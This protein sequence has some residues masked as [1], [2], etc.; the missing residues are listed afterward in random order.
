LE[1]TKR[2]KKVVL[3][4]DG[5]V[6]SSYAFSLLQ[7]GVANELSVVDIKAKERHTYGDI[8]DL[9]DVLPLT[10]PLR[11]H[12]GS[13]QD[14]SDAD[15]VVITAGVPRKSGE[16]RLDLV[17]KNTKI[18][19]SIIQPIIESGF[20]GIFLISCNPVDI[21]TTLTQKL[22]G[23]PKERVIGTGTMLDTARLQVALS[24]RLNVSLQDIDAM[25]LGEHGDSSFAAYGEAKIGGQL[26][27][28]ISS[29][30]SITENDLLEIQQQVH[31]KGNNIIENKGSTFYGVAVVLMR[32]TKAILNNES[33]ITPISAPLTGQ[34]GLKD[35][36]IGTPALINANGIANVFEEKLTIEELDK[37]RSSADK[38][39]EV[40]KNVE[41]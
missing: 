17:N 21:L 36:Y 5:A 31:A 24:N 39:L 10:S 22:S 40:L 41:K 33:L 38:M 2:N 16:S 25:I 6:G 29:Q 27:K 30:K 8:L 13:Y 3:V 14:A 15:L 9:E 32:I 12:V 11:L 35:I 1:K 18:L 20:N 23:F 26:L 34:Y 4:G 19:K 37:M 28:N 7:N